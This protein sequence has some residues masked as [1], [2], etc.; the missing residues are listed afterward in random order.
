LES[1]W[2]RQ[3]RVQLLGAMQFIRAIGAEFAPLARTHH[4]LHPSSVTWL[5]QVLHVRVCQNDFPCT[6]VTSDSARRVSHRCTK[7]SPL[8]V[9]KGFVRGAETSPIDLDEDLSWIIRI[10]VAMRKN[11]NTNLD[12]ALEGPQFV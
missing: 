11:P 9:Q 7:G 3:A 12:R 10:A 2:R 4:P 5:P 8:V 6:F 1:A